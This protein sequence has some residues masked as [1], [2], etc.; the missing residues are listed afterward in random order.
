MLMRRPTLIRIAISLAGCSLMFVPLVASAAHA[1]TAQC[2]KVSAVP[3]AHHDS[4]ERTFTMSGCRPVAL[5]GGGGTSV[6]NLRTHVTTTNWAQG[7]GTTTVYATWDATPR[8][9]RCPTSTRLV[10]SAGTVTGGTGAALDA[11]AVG[12]SFNARATAR[13]TRRSRSSRVPAIASRRCP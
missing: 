1:A 5:L 2:T 3:N 12:E 8:P 11:V 4:A 7:K 10:V 9:S 13:P 6:T